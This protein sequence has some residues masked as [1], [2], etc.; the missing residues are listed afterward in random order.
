MSLSL[1]SRREALM[2]DMKSIKEYIKTTLAVV[3]ML[4]VIKMLHGLVVKYMEKQYKL[5]EKIDKWEI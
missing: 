4:C 5:I 2:C 1:F 3:S